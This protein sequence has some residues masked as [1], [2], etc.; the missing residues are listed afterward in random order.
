ML[1]PM[2][3]AA[4]LAWDGRSARYCLSP[5]CLP[6]PPPLTYA[7]VHCFY[8]T[9]VDVSAAFGYRPK[10][11]SHGSIVHTCAS[12]THPYPSRPFARRLKAGGGGS[13]GPPPR[14]SA[15]ATTLGRL[16]SYSYAGRDEMGWD[17][18]VPRSGS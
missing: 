1:S 2:R 18:G 13:G 12:V 15:V 11:E 8:C 10:L 16:G 9:M 5:A 6:S 7:S 17:E 14:E 3:K 4:G